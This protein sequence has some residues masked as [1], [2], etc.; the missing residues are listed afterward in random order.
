M[1]RRILGGHLGV[2]AVSDTPNPV[3]NPDPDFQRQYLE[4]KKIAHAARAAHAAEAKQPAP[5]T[6]KK[7][8]DS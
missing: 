5:K 4:A 1:G 8:V 7:S 3:P 6:P 2:H